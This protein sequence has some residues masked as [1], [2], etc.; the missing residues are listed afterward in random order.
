MAFKLLPFR[1]RVELDDGK[2]NMGTIVE[3]NLQGYKGL[4]TPNPSGDPEIPDDPPT[5]HTHIA[6]LESGA[7]AVTV[8]GDPFVVM[9]RHNILAYMT[10]D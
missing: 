4:T 6:F 10:E 7:E 3:H 1:V 9:H 8:D 2:T 5:F